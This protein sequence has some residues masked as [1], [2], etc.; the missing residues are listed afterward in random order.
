MTLQSDVRALGRDARLSEDPPM[1]S[2][3]RVCGSA[4]RS[5]QERAAQTCAY[6]L[7][8]NKTPLSRR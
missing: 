4:L 8:V 7:D 3:C 2:S 6:H 5:T 1:A